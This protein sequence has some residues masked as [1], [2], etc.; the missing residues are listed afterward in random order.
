[1]FLFLNIFADY[2]KF[3]ANGWCRV[4]S[5]P[6]IFSTKIL[7]FSCILIVMA[8]FPF[9][10]PIIDATAC[11]GGISMHMWTWSLGIC[12]SIHSFC[13]ANSWK[14][15]PRNARISPY[16]TLRLY[17]GT[18]IM[19]YLQSYFEWDK[20]WYNWDMSNSLRF[21]LQATVGVTL[22]QNRPKLF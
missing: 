11:L 2:L 3:K 13:L 21:K 12:P 19:W 18:K 7:C 6:K 14:T 22:L 20:L 4:A 9:R 8:L 16:K 5:C 10:K 1:M 17:L 15:G